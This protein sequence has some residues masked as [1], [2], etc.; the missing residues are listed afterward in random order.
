MPRKNPYNPLRIIILG[1]IFVIVLLPATAV[2]WGWQSMFT[3]LGRLPGRQVI[4]VLFLAGL[5]LLLVGTFTVARF[6][7][8]AEDEAESSAQQ[9]ANPISVSEKMVVW[10]GLIVSLGQITLG[11]ALGIVLGD[12]SKTAGRPNLY[13]WFYV[14]VGVLIIVAATYFATLDR[15]L[16]AWLDAYRGGVGLFIGSGLGAL[17]SRLNRGN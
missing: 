16:V 11:S 14:I 13:L 4:G 17:L 12:L 1:S 15:E 3:L 8:S 10:G 2:I 5:I 9:K 6:S 7:Q